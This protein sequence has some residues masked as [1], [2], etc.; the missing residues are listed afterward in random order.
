MENNTVNIDGIIFEAVPETTGC[1]G[2]AF[3]DD[4]GEYNCNRSKSSG[5]DCIS[6]E[7][8][9]RPY[10]LKTGSA[11]KQ[12]GGTHY[13]KAIQPWDIIRE[14]NLDYWRGN[15]IKYVLRCHEKNG[16]E[17]LKKAIH[18]LEYAIEH[19]EEEFK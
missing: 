10:A 7:I 4:V 12:V 15:V 3:K 14:W 2:C 8:I 17:D 1:T 6:D 13:Q 16:I 9:W 5:I 11:M 19:Y 18:Y